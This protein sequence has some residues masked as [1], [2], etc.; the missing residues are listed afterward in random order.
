[1]TIV[2][3]MLHRELSPEE[4]QRILENMSQELTGRAAMFTHAFGLLHLPGQTRRE[5]PFPQWFREVIEKSSFHYN[6]VNL[7]YQREFEREHRA[8]EFMDWFDRVLRIYCA[9]VG[10]EDFAKLLHV[11]VMTEHEWTVDSDSF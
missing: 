4:G 1:M 7:V 6:D 11:R 2:Q 3:I 8:I 9:G 5:N 10:G